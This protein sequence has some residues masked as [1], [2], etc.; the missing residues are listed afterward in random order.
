MALSFPNISRSYD[1]SH[2]CVRFWGHD[3]TFEISFFVDIEALSKLQGLPRS[4][5]ASILSAFDRCRE[6]I[7]TV[8][9][10]MY[11]R[12]RSSSYRIA[13]ADF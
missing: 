10:A 12:H 3:G 13:A 4:D 5:E 7:I 8:A 9:A 2:R 1:E 11:R 6:R